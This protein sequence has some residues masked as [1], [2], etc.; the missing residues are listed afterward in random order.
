MSVIG[1]A[2]PSGGLAAVAGL[3]RGLVVGWLLPLVVVLGVVQLIVY[4]DTSVPGFA[5]RPASGLQDLGS[6]S[7]LQTRFAQDA[8]HPR[9]L[10]LISPT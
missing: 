3:V 5:T 7:D 8:G 9:L 1:R 6:L 2:A 4:R 10:L